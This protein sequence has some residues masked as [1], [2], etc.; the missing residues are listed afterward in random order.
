MDSESATES[1]DFSPRVRPSPNLRNICGHKWWFWVV[2]S[3]V[4]IYLSIGGVDTSL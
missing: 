3:R 2:C 1:A 4:N